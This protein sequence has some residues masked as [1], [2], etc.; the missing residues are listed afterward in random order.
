MAPPK[1][2]AG[3]TVDKR[4]GHKGMELVAPDEAPKPPDGILP[5]TQDWWY[6]YW[7]D[8][9]AGILTP[10]DRPVVERWIT[11]LDRMARLMG[12]ADREPVV[13]G[14]Q[15]QP[16]PNPLYDVALRFETSVRND[17][18][19]LGIGPKNRAALGIL[20]LQEKRSLDKLNASYGGG[21]ASSDEDEDPRL[22]IAGD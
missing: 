6:A 22:Q 3:R 15:G 5:V 11:N 17:E 2:H 8:R 20:A 19:Q 10:A 7:S 9:A 18:A 14:S 13:H 21:H 16:R 1:K 4:N 12:E